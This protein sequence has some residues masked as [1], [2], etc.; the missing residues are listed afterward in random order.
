MWEVV[1]RYYF[2]HP[3]QLEAGPTA[4]LKGF[5]KS[6]WLFM[7]AG[8]C[9]AAGL[10]SFELISF[11]FDKTGVVSEH[12]IPLYFAVAM[13]TDAIASLIFGKLF[14]RYGMVIVLIAFLLSAC[15]PPFVFW[16]N[17][18]GALIGMILW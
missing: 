10:M 7:I 3:S 18:V 5:T 4:R 15:F 6:Y 17:S 1:A 12:W 2:P 16:G 11:H 14:D 8:A 13:G 9:I